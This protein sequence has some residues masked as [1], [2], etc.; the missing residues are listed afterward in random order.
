MPKAAANEIFCDPIQLRLL[1]GERLRMME[2]PEFV[3]NNSVTVPTG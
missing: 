3:T 1:F 2:K